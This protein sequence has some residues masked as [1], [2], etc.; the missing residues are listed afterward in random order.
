MVAEVDLDVE[1]GK[2]YLSKRLTEEGRIYYPIFL[3]AAFREG[4]EKMLEDYLTYN[5][6]LEKR[7]ID[8][9]RVRKV[10]RN[11][12][13][14]IAQ[15]EFNRYYIRAVC[16]RAIERGHTEVEVY[17]ARSSYKNRS[18]SD[19]K[20]GTRINAALLLDDL[21]SSPGEEPRM[22]PEINSGLSVKI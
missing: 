17:R 11:A 21:R 22:L 19:E 4:D 13:Q 5:K 16:L 12:A 8:K 2:L 1:R 15:S 3:R 10:P 9:E 14:L 18:S 6:L 20:V 7:E